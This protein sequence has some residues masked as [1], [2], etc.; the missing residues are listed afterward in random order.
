[1]PL[2]YYCELCNILL[3]SS[4]VLPSHIEGEDHVLNKSYSHIERM[5]NWISIKQVDNFIIA[6]DDILLTKSAWNAVIED[7]CCL[8]NKEL[9]DVVQH[10]NEQMHILKLIQSVLQ[11]DFNNNVYRK[12]SNMF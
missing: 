5:P 10:Y 2:G 3:Y 7:S 8:C 4:I 6:F 9:A 12:V 11:V 1:M